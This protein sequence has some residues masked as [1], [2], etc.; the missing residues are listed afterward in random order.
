MDMLHIMQ[1]QSSNATTND[2]NFATLKQDGLC[3]KS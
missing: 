2:A 3:C 1:L